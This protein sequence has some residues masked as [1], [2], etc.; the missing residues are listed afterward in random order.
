MGPHSAHDADAAA[1]LKEVSHNATLFAPELNVWNESGTKEA[2]IADSWGGWNVHRNMSHKWSVSDTRSS[3]ALLRAN[4]DCVEFVKAGV[5]SDWPKSQHDSRWLPLEDHLPTWL[6]PRRGPA[7]PHVCQ[8][9]L[10]VFCTE[11]NSVAS[12][13]PVP[14]GVGIVMR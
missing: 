12:I 11:M 10:A 1:S 7:S 8:F 2:R 4:G 14:S 9:V 13:M 5:E 3:L 6:Q